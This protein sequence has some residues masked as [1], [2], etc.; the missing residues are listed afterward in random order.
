MGISTV[1]FDKAKIVQNKMVF[2]RYGKK[3]VLTNILDSNGT[4]LYSRISHPSFKKITGDEVIITKQREY[5]L[6][7]NKIVFETVKR[8][9]DK[10]GKLKNITKS[11]KSY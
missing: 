6:P 8:F 10:T 9:Y 3:G 11:T 1:S 4:L 5:E 7:D 2:L